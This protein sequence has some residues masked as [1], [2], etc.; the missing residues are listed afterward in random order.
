MEYRLINPIDNNKSII[1]Q[2][3]SNRGI[4]DTQHYLNTTDEDINDPLLL[5]NMEAAADA[6]LCRL[7]N[8][9]KIYVQVDSD[10]DGCLSASLLLNYLHRIF[11]K[12][13]EENIIFNNHELKVHGVDIDQVPDDVS[14]VII[15]DAGSNQTEEHDILITK[16]SGV[17]VA[18]HHMYCGKENSKAIIIN[19]QDGYY[20]NTT[21]SGAGVVYKLCQ[22]LDKKLGANYADD[23]LDMAAVGI[24]GDVMSLKDYETIQ[25]IRKG[26]MRI[27]NPFLKTIIEK[28]SFS[29]GKEVTPFGIAFY[30][31]P[32]INAVT[33]VGSLQERDLLFTSMLEWKSY[34]EIPSTKRGCQGQ[35]ETRV[36]QAVR[37]CG[38]IKA[39]Q[40]KFKDEI[41]SNVESIIKEQNLLQDKVLIVRVPQEKNINKGLT[42]LVATELANK[43]NRPTFVLN[44][45]ITE[46]GNTL[47]MGSA[48]GLSQAKDNNLLD[49]CRDSLLFSLAEGHQLAFGAGI[50]DENID[51]VK[52]YFEEKYKNEDFSPLYFVDFIFDSRYISPNF[53][54][55]IG[56]NKYLWGQDV[57]EPKIALENIH[58]TK[59]NLTLMSKDKNPTLKIT[60]PNGIALI[61]FKSSEE[62]FNNLFSDS[63]C[64][65]INAVGTCSINEYRGRITPQIFIENYNIVERQKYFF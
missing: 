5:K 62:E 60:L 47:W 38:N 27:R 49:S 6:I 16:Y 31:V 39:H 48:R 7:R 54:L 21:L 23:Y 59:D 61:K 65:V 45:I 32:F 13:V 33:R 41:T 24:I 8:N 9:Q 35:Y 53:V 58:I 2:I 63:G 10:S 44:E 18:D 34:E 36:E 42:G 25:I 15:P 50:S 28:N 43:Y 26:L 17:V 46:D 52:E 55:T 12:E 19:N 37:M 29:I 3:L 40:K 30:V 64:V 51:K 1:E 11:P 56:E 4:E 14:L 20:P 22:Y 57:G